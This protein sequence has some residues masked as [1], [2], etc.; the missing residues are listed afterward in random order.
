MMGGVGGAIR[1][2]YVGLCGGENG[3][4]QWGTLEIMGDLN[5]NP[6]GEP[7]PSGEPQP[8]WGTLK[9][10]HNGESQP[11]RGTSALVGNPKMESQWGTPMGNPKMDPQWGTSTSVGEPQQRT[12]MGAPS[13]MANLNLYGEP[14]RGTPIENS[15]KELP[16]IPISNL[17]PQINGPKPQTSNPKIPISNPKPHLNAL[18][19]QFLPH[20]PNPDP[21]PQTSYPKIPISNPTTTIIA[22]QTPII[23]AKT[24][25]SNPKNPLLTP[26]Q[27]YYP[28][29]PHF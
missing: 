13:P 5:W 26:N 6:N 8:R 19:P 29:N 10:N 17:K 12:P 11:Q 1:G 2:V 7:N 3:G 15:N 25:I 4:D 16:Q 22:P 21:K 24:P 28:P 9:W 20:I 18:R 23:T 14:Q 27:N